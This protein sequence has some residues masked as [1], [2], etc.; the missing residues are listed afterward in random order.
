MSSKIGPDRR[1]WSLAMRLT[2]W[3]AG[4]TFVL[5]LAATAFL[6]WAL[7]SSLDREDDEFL[8]DK[9]R[10]LR[11][12][13]R[14][15]P[16]DVSAIRQEAEWAWSARQHTQVYVRI[17]DSNHQVILETPGMTRMLPTAMFPAPVAADAEPGEGLEAVA[18]TGQA[19]R[20]VAA[21]A[22]EGPGAGPARILQVAMDRS[23]E[24]SLLTSFRR[25]VWLVLGLAVVACALGGYQIARHGI[26][27]IRDIAGTARRIRSTTLNERLA[28]SGLPREIRDL[29]ETFNQML[30]RLEESFSRLAQF[31]ADIAHELRTPL[32]NLRG[33]TEVA[34][35]KSRSPEEYR[36]VLGSNLEE[37]AR[38]SGMVDSLLFLAR[39]ENPRTQVRRQI[40]EL[41]S[42]L[43]KVRE[44]YE[45]TAAEAHVNLALAPNAPVLADLDRPLVQRAVSNL[46]D[47]ALAHTPAGG[48]VTLSTG[49]HGALLW[50]EVA[51]TGV[52]IAKEDIPHLCDRFY[53]TDRARTAGRG[54]VG[55]GL[56]IVKSIAELHGG[57]VKVASEL[58]RG[59]RVK[60]VFPRECM[61]TSAAPLA[62]GEHSQA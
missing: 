61:A 19:L 21:C 53:R 20:L 46:V 36:E 49:Q 16:A 45:P 62:A 58:G 18:T 4:T 7:I 40:L 48:T 3:Y 22:V 32:N 47:N 27:P 31:S 39:A 9:V 55:L 52:G 43:E 23:D 59:T 37:F 25:S 29:A 38:L 28:V 54:G 14:K 30:D 6:Y 33:E 2:A 44:F 50:I 24:E 17:L 42:E 8:A 5:I 26:R 10:V 57:T 56:A 34:L 41:H 60:L 15:R 13:L 51:D 11:T 12:V 1:P 35:S